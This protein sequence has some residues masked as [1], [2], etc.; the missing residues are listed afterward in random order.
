MNE[1]KKFLSARRELM[2]DHAVGNV[3]LIE[4]AT[5]MATLV[6]LIDEA[7]TPVADKALSFWLESGTPHRKGWLR[8]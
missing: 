6:E 3:R 4:F 8:E 7:R 1:A 5:R 2:I